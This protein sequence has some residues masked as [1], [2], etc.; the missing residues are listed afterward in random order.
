VCSITMQSSD[1]DGDALT[2]TY[3]WYRDNVLQAGLTGDTVDSSHTAAGE[4]WECVVTATDGTDGSNSSSDSVSVEPDVFIAA[5]DSSQADRDQADHI[6]DGSRDEVQLRAAI[7]SLG[8]SGGTIYIAEGT[9]TADDE[10]IVEED[11]VTIMG[12]G[13]IRRSSSGDRLFYITL[14]S[15]FRMEGLELSALDGGQD[16]LVR[17]NGCTNVYVSN[18][19]I[20]DCY[21][22][23][24]ARSDTS[25]GRKSSNI[26]MTDNE[27]YNI[28]Y[29]A[30][31]LK[32]G[33]EY[34]YVERNV[35]HDGIQTHP[36]L[37]YAIATQSM[38][39]WDED[40]PI[41]EWVYI[42]DNLIYNWDVSSPVDVHGGNHIVVEGNSIRNNAAS[43]AI[44]LHAIHVAGDVTELHDWRVLENEI[45]GTDRGI[46]IEAEYGIVVNDVEVS[47]NTIKEFTSSGIY[48]SRTTAGGDGAELHH[49]KIN[50]NEISDHIGIDSSGSAGI[51]L[52]T[53]E[54]GSADDFE[55]LRNQIH[56]SGSHDN[57]VYGIRVA[58]VDNGVIDD[59]EVTGSF[60]SREIHVTDSSNVTV[61]D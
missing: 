22:G 12:E 35:I 27:L 44:Y 1:A 55:I 21:R 51:R 57:L 2:Y 9:Y 54:S 26:Y 58:R 25:S 20:H 36:S 23:V 52:S 46:W 7:D 34:A 3:Q 37:L 13:H 6:C 40:N 24:G 10:I 31:G 38:G 45:V 49:I 18:C 30:L 56:G 39:E 5:Y 53:G 14:C 33:C 47:G 29:C 60:Q 42:T 50:D 59:N 15:D 11:N 28:H 61:N 43:S 16:P 41:N 8:S 4:I 48:I 19:V 17:I 32:N